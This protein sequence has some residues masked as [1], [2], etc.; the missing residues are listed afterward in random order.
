M[1]SEKINKTVLVV[2]DVQQMCETAKLSFTDMNGDKNCPY[3]F[4]I[5]IAISTAECIEKVRLKNYDVIV[6]DIVMMGRP[7]DDKS[8][9][10]TALAVGLNEQLG[11]ETP[12]R[13]IW[14]G[15]PSYSDCVEAMRHG[16]WDYIVKKDVDGKTMGEILVDSAIVRLRQLDIYQEQTEQIAKYWL[17]QHFIELQTKYSG[18][19]VA[20]WHKPDIFIIASGRDAFDLEVNL[21]EWRKLHTRWEQPWIVRIPPLGDEKEA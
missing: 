1:T 4:D 19:I 20:L 11:Y 7:G 16:A 14:T 8:G 6:L 3:I 17:P 21:N 18:E 12:I 5:D 10:E 13:I 15:Y 2:D 9:L